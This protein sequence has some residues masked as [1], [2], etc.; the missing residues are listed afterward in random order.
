MQAVGGV[1]HSLIV[2]LN[3]PSFMLVVRGKYVN[4]SLKRWGQDAKKD[5]GAQL[6]LNYHVC[7]SPKGGSSGPVPL[8]PAVERGP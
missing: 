5:L 3:P 1:L 8:S 2:G 4:L 7:P 6:I